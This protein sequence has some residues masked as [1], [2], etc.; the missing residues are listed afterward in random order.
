MPTG[1]TSGNTLSFLE[2]LLIEYD[3]KN[4]NLRKLIDENARL[5]ETIF[6]ETGAERLEKLIKATEDRN[7]EFKK[8]VA[9]INKDFKDDDKITFKFSTKHI[10]ED[11]KK[12]KS[13]IEEF[14]DE[15]D[16]MVKTGADKDEIIEKRKNLQKYKEA[17]NALKE[18]AT[19]FYSAANE[20]QKELNRR[21]LEGITALDDWG[22]KWEQRTRAVRKGAG[23]VSNGVKQIYNSITKTLEPWAKANHEAMELQMLILKKLFHG[24]QRIILVYFSIKLL[25]NLL[26]CRVN[27][28]KFSVEMYN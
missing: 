12:L 8:I 22:E 1:S 10:E 21:Q 27:T 15:I 13:I 23:E 4:E 17:Y 18:S 25:M 7:N 20:E 16:E 14:Q 19:D 9:S 5:N 11:L 26:K 28:L 6:N 3:R 24:Q 2:K